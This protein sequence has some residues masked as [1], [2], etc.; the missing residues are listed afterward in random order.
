MQAT[1]RVMSRIFVGVSLVL[2]LIGFDAAARTGQPNIVILFADDLGY[3]DLGT[4]GHPT[5][6]TP[7]LDRMAFEGIKLTSFYSAASLC[8]P[9]RAALLTGRYPIRSGLV[10]V[11]FPGSEGGIPDYEVTL[12]EALRAVG[13]ATAC[14]GKWHLGH[15]PQFLPTAHGFDYYFGLPY[16]ND[17]DRSDRGHPPLPLMRNTEIVE[18]PA[19]EDTLTLRYTEEALGFIEQSVAR[20]VPFFLYLPYTMVHVPLSVSDDFR[21]TSLRGRYGDA[22]EEIDW[23]VGRILDGLRS[24]GISE[25][26]LVV[27]TSDNGP[28]L[29]R[30]LAGGTAT[31]LRGGKGSTWEGGMR[32]PCIAWWPGTI[33]ENAVSGL[34]ATTMDLFS[35]AI[36]LA[37]ADLPN[38]R[39]I[40]GMNILPLLLGGEME[41]EAPFFYYSN[42]VSSHVVAIRNG[43]W[44]LHVETRD[45]WQ[46]FA[47]SEFIVNED[48]KLFQIQNDP[49]EKHDLASEHQE[50]VRE[51]S[52]QLDYHSMGVIP[53]EAQT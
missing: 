18:V 16:S 52:E 5:I 28:W 9:S 26:T 46:G 32:V 33:P 12:A 10:T 11:L 1:F 14:I 13:Y 29:T 38:D 3:S 48:P 7:N 27:F 51:L 17:M 8:T 36:F 41:R 47:T 53:G 30:M 22:V 4:F 43:A 34:V 39:I 23:S 25:N 35:T 45:K 20:G 6:R 42:G 21:D 31:P 49:F 40:D 44:K 19:D 15:L 50:I 2:V 37:G 24:L